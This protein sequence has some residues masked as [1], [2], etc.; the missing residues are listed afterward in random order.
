M[1]ETITPILTKTGLM[2]RLFVCTI[3]AAALTFSAPAA[4][5][6]KP[7]HVSRRAPAKQFARP[8][9]GKVHGPLVAPPPWASADDYRKK[10]QYKT[11]DGQLHQFVPSDLVFAPGAGIGRCN[12]ETLAAIV[13]AVAGGVVGGKQSDGSVKLL[14]DI[15]GAIV[16]AVVGG[17]LGRTMDRVDQNCVGQIL[18][19]APTDS[20]VTWQ[21][22]HRGTT[23][24]VNVSRTYQ[25]KGGR[26]CR[27]YETSAVI[28][29]KVE[30]TRGTACRRH[31]GSWQ[32]LN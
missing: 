24:N 9:K 25:D 23:Y 10:F 14:V 28:G 31:N 21:D 19:H 1:C 4:A 3:L 22:P 29:G 12:R 8:K 7:D 16:D 18:E 17:N 26:Y 6:H 11:S 32:T 2:G 13:G 27:E 15:G 20:L 5:H 30:M